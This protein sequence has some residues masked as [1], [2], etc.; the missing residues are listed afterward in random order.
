MFEIEMLPAREGDCLWIRY[1][2]KDCPRQILIDG[3]RQGTFRDIKARLMALPESQRQFELFVITHVDRDHIEGALALLED[4]DL[5]LTFKD[6]WFNGYRHLKG[7]ELESFGA[8]QGESLTTILASRNQPWNASFNGCAV[9][10][11][12]KGELPKV[13]LAGGL[14]L[15]VLSP[16]SAK[17]A[18]LLPSWEVECERAGLRPGAQGRAEPEGLESFGGRVD[19]ER[20]ASQPFTPDRTPANGSSIALLAEF[21][22]VRV[23]LA[24]DAHTDRLVSSLRTLLG[25][26]GR[27][28]L[29]AFKL[30]HHGSSKNTS[31]ELLELVD[32]SRYLVST[33]GSYFRHPDVVTLARVLKFGGAQKVLYF[34]YRSDHSGP[35]MD[36]GLQE[37]YG[38][39]A[40]AP[41]EG[42]EGLVV[43]LQA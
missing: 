9:K 25:G 8:V 32:C 42:T 13:H 15:T 10:I 21:E 28:H 16:D 33:S 19:V 5:R 38:Y 20:L 24:A 18:T 2:S 14:E 4:P 40:E 22:G 39:T 36:P 1:G 11:G 31:S 37:S 3:G 27:V 17:L 35:W 12:E 26:G 6:V 43:L 29:D 34:N 23:L 30:S 7:D 41:S